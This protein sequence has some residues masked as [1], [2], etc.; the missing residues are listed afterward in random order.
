L[1]ELTIPDTVF[2][3]G[4]EAFAWCN[5]LKEVTLPEGLESIEYGL[6]WNAKKLEKVNIPSS[7]TNIC[8]YAFALCESLTSI[9]LSPD[10]ISLGEESFAYCSNLKKIEFPDQLTMICKKAFLNNYSLRQV[11]VR[12]GTAY[13]EENVFEGCKN[14]QFFSPPDSAVQAYVLGNED[15]WEKIVTITYMG[16]EIPSDQLPITRSS[17]TLVPV[18]AVFEA[19]GATVE[20]IGSDQTVA[21][22]RNDTLIFLTMDQH[23][24]WVNGNAVQLDVAPVMQHGRIFVPVRAIAE[25]LHCDIYWD[26]ATQTVSIWEKEN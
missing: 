22:S 3:I 21:M 4:K 26:E 16:H 10:V 23:T 11:I 2:R 24:M 14:L 15:A 9:Q 8:D 6:F 19:M 5:N 20:W 1:K 13:F 18:R 7:V 17:R 12:N 25:G